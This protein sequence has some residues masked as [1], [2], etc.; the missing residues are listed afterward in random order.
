M[1]CH[2]SRVQGFKVKILGYWLVLSKNSIALCGE[3]D[4][5]N[6]LRCFCF[7]CKPKRN[8]W[9]LHRHRTR[10][11]LF[12]PAVLSFQNYSKVL[13]LSTNSLFVDICIHA[14]FLPNS[15]ALSRHK[16]SWLCT[17]NRTKG[18]VGEEHCQPVLAVTCKRQFSLVLMWNTF[19]FFMAFAL[20]TSCSKHCCEAICSTSCRFCVGRGHDESATWNR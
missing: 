20:R 4:V 15:E 11:K 12:I 2:D 5:E 13:I 3:R 19:F 14:K 10:V 17:L 1:C 6:D 9:P 7:L 18:Q 8:Q 16:G